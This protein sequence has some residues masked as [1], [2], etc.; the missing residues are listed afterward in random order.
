[1]FDIRY[2]QITGKTEKEQLMQIK[3]YLYQIVPQLQIALEN[4]ATKEGTSTTP[5]SAK[6]RYSQGIVGVPTDPQETF[7]SIKALIIKS[8]DIVNAYYEE[9]SR[10]LDGEYVA[11]SDFGIFSESTTSTITEDST[12]INNLFT[13]V[14]EII[15]GTSTT[16]GSLSEEM[17][18]IKQ[19]LDDAKTDIQ[20]SLGEL[21]DGL[22]GV[23][24]TIVD[25]TANVKTGLLYYDDEATPIY[26]L[27]VGQT[28]VVNGEEVFNKFARFTSD[29]LS[30]YNAYGNEVAYISDN[31]LYINDAEINGTLTIGRYI[32]DSSNGLAF[33]RVEG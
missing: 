2:P 30:F 1:M 29:R 25:V 9:I 7:N 14:Q 10:K 15:D 3:S 27:E 5:S 23:K 4:L 18:D 24:Q 32:I 17:S 21:A 8:A 19:G 20:G 28:N 16:F 22:E 31:K 12:K 26:G 13:S 11:V 6:D 33:K